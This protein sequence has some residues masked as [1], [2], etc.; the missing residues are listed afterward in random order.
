MVGAG[1]TVT[2]MAGAA[3]SYIFFFSGA[4]GGRA[5]ALAAR[6]M[7]L[8]RAAVGSC[9]SSRINSLARSIGTRTNPLPWSCQ[10]YFSSNGLLAALKSDKICIRSAARVAA[11]EGA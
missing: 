5:N 3:H 9:H 1:E 6:A 11:M 10:S 2:F 8:E 7:R 4:L